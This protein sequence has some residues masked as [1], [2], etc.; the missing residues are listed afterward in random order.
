MVFNGYDLAPYLLVTDVKAMVV[1]PRR[2]TTAQ[3]PG[4]DGARV[5]SAELDALEIHVPAVIL[6]D[7]MEDVTECCAALAGMLHTD[8]DAK[9]ILPNDPT[10][11]YMAMYEGGA[12]PSR[13]ISKPD[14]ELVF[15]AGD[16][17][18]YGRERTETLGGRRTVRSGGTYRALPTVTVRPPAGESW[19]ITNVTTGEFVR[20]FADFDGTQELVLDMGLERCTVNGADHMVDG[21]SDFFPINGADELMV[22]GG[23][24]TLRWVERWL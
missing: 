11:Y 2:L 9:L 19:S 15:Y 22:S 7:T 5:Q 3:A 24:A 13:L 16:P 6:R 20:V 8:R 17:V 12:E 21:L 23:T 14:V 4:V 1:P 18:R 10:R